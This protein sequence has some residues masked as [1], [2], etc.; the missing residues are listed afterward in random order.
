MV[1]ASV[2]AINF[3]FTKNPTQL[4]LTAGIGRKTV[5][6]RFKTM[7]LIALGVIFGNPTAPFSIRPFI[8][9]AVTRPSALKL[10]YCQIKE[11]TKAPGAL[12]RIMQLIPTTTHLSFQYFER[13][14]NLIFRI[15]KLQIPRIYWSGSIGP[16]RNFAI[17]NL[18]FLDV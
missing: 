3:D 12:N 9:Y 7:E 18:D 5:I 14:E 10:L 17:Q 4:L 13:L 16:K 15:L 11:I 2:T 1:L 8:I 6:V